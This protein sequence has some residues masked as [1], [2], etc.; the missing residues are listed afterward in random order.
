MD[1]FFRDN[2]DL[3]F[4]LGDGADWESLVNVTE[5]GFRTPDGFRS[6]AE[7]K[8][9]YREMLSAVGDMAANVIAPLA[10]RLDREESAVV[11]G[12]VIESDALQEASEAMRAAELQKLCLPREL[13]G[14]NAPLLVY[15]LSTELMARADV[16][17]MTHYSFH[18]A[19]GM[20][21]LAFSVREGTT[22]FDPKQGRI[23][24][25]RFAEYI[26]DIAR[27]NAWGCMDITE[28]AAGSD[29]AKLSC[30]GTQDDSGQW[31]LF[32]EKVFITSGHGKYHFVV[33]RTEDVKDPDD[34]FAG[35]GG[36]SMFLVKAFDDLP[37]GTRQRH[38]TV[39]R[40][41]EKLGHHGSVTAALS[42]DGSPAELIGKRGEGFAYMLTL[43]NNARVGVAFEGVGL[44]EAALRAAQT[45][46]EGRHSM[47][48]AIVHHEM[49][50]DLLDET[51]T[52]I[53]GIRAL[54]VASATHEEMSQ[55]LAILSRFGDAL[56]GEERHRIEHDLPRHRRLARRYTPLLKYLSSERA[57]LAARRSLQI[58]GGAGYTRDY[59]PEKLLRDSL[60]LPIYEGTSQIQSLMAMKDTLLGV[61]K[62]PG[63]FV[64]KGA[65]M[66]VAALSARD[67]LVRGVARLSTTVAK[68]VTFLLSRTAGDK[69]RSL[70]SLPTSSWLAAL[71]K[72]WDPKRDFSLAMLHAEKLTQLLADEAV[73]EVLLDQCRRDPGRRVW[74][75]RWLERAEPRS[76]AM[77]DLIHTTGARTLARVGRSSEAPSS[78]RATT[79][80]A[81]E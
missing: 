78:S 80:S 75:E 74:L 56:T 3:N 28:P 15:F 40:I 69:L 7:A 54:A 34:A 24:S 35:L 79:G 22:T 32:G 2:D 31:R 45:Y 27:G 18:G 44:S 50:A 58:H 17:F 51:E 61:I 36:L 33:A 77:S 1:N 72:D 20:A 26:E 55:K 12:D 30:R 16:S 43:M 62:N 19:M 52:E 64:R 49:I 13:S 81:A 39:D 47:G 4:Y 37:N 38:I 57:V 73:A 42:F 59:V 10:P 71:R 63:A 14:L 29:M 8:E 6:V 53:R 23:A 60:V 21:M 9:F 66:R 5:Y 41:E 67:P 11:D 48:K 46:A 25:T 76:R 65:D 68:V 70:T